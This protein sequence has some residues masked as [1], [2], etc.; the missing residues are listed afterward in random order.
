M[1]IFTIVII[2]VIVIAIIIVIA[3]VMIAIVM[4]AVSRLLRVVIRK[5]LI[6]ILYDQLVVSDPSRLNHHVAILV[7][8][9]DGV[10]RLV[11]VLVDVVERQDLA[12]QQ[13]AQ[14]DYHLA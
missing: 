14:K 12:L 8:N 1:A 4:I 5:G 9:L 2:I 3:I 6:Q 7:A 11:L 10:V 13:P